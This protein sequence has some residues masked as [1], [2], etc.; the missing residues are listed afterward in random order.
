MHLNCSSKG[1]QKLSPCVN[2]FEFCC[3]ENISRVSSSPQIN[4]MHSKRRQLRELAH[5]LK[6][7]DNSSSKCKRSKK[8]KKKKWKSL[9]NRG[10]CTQAG[11]R[12]IIGSCRGSCY[13]SKTS[14]FKSRTTWDSTFWRSWNAEVK[15]HA[16]VLVDDSLWRNCSLNGL[17]S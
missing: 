13:F 10:A 9:A 14:N 17:Y 16:A 11:S 7:F 1:S 6:E 5:V 8:K 4:Y 3:S 15:L 2:S 12:K